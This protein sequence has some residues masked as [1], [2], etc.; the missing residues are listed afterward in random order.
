MAQ[1]NDLSNLNG[2]FKNVYG[3]LHNLIPD[4]VKLMNMVP[5]ANA[6]E[7]LGYRFVEAVVL[8]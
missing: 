2:L 8:G 4:N 7:Q 6:Q 5:F 3:K 1:N